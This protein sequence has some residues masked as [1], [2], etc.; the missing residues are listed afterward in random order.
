MTRD[1][2]SRISVVETEIAVIKED[3]REIKA[4]VKKLLRS[5]AML[6]LLRWAIPGMALAIS[7]AAFFFK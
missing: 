2:L 5:D 3:V 4:D 6:S 1:E 7:L